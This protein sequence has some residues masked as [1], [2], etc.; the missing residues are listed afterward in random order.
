MDEMKRTEHVIDDDLDVGFFEVGWADIVDHLLQIVW[1][2]FQHEENTFCFRERLIRF[3]G[4]DD[5]VE[6]SHAEVLLALSKLSQNCNLPDDITKSK[7]VVKIAFD[8]FDREFLFSV[9]LLS[10]HHLAES[11]LSEDGG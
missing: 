7:C 5:V 10:I 11:T 6:A 4:E 2:V 9:S 3:H 1:L 8:E